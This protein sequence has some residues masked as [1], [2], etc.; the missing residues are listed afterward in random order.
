MI[1]Q[2]HSC[3]L[4]SLTQ[5]LPTLRI[6]PKLFE[7]DLRS[8]DR[9]CM[10]TASGCQPPLSTESGMRRRQGSIRSPSSGNRS[11]R[12]SDRKRRNSII[13]DSVRGSNRKGKG[14]IVDRA[15]G[16]FVQGMIRDVLVKD[17]VA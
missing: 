14:G 10:S 6:R 16:D 1:N 8:L 11:V 7:M 17:D 5:L 15:R 3:P 9:F 12:R 4:P 13:D 2:Q